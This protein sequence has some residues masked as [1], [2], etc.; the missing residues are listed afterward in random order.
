MGKYTNV[1]A[2]LRPK[3]EISDFQ[4][5]V[6][7]IK[8]SVQDMSHAALA[9][10][11]VEIRAEKD[12]VKQALSDVNIRLVAHEQLLTDAFEEAGV[13]NLKLDTGESIS[14]QVK[15]YA[16]IQDRAAF[17]NWCIDNG[18]EESLVLPWQSTNALVADRLIEGLPEPDGIETYKQTTVVLRKGRS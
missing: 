18:L 7:Q 8:D 12:T 3:P 1:A 5:K 9:K 15:P 11:I 13:A 10:A 6:N 14:T 4:D 16:R 17:R 2:H